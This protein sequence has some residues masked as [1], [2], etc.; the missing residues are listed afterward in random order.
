[1]PSQTEPELSDKAEL[2]HK[3]SFTINTNSGNDVREQIWSVDPVF[4][5]HLTGGIRWALGLE[6]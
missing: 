3:V 6:N 2:G 1:M 4:Q 5:A